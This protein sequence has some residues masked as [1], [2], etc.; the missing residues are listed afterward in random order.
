M[1]TYKSKQI[2][3]NVF[4]EQH[5]D[6]SPADIKPKTRSP[7]PTTWKLNIL[8]GKREDEIKDEAM[9][10][11]RRRCRKKAMEFIKCEQQNGK[12]WTVFEC[13]EEY[14]KMNE[15][16][17]RETEIEADRLRRDISRHPEWWWREFYDE[18][19]EI[20]EQAAWKDEW[21]GSLLFQKLKNKYFGSSESSTTSSQ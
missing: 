3:H 5:L 21:W 13:I 20:G 7:K 4:D 15:C 6:E 19:G 12:Y 8:R 14:E 16:F 10:L 9:P 11:A 1:G 2:Q 18:D 17:Q